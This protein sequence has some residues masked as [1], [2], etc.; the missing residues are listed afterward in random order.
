LISDCKVF[1][2]GIEN[3]CAAFNEWNSWNGYDNVPLRADSISGGGLVSGFL[4]HIAAGFGHDIFLLRSLVN[5]FR[6]KNQL[7]SSFQKNIYL[8]RE[9]RFVSLAERVIEN[10]FSPF[11]F[12]ADSR[13]AAQPKD[14]IWRLCKKKDIALVLACSP[15]LWVL[16]IFC[17]LLQKTK[18]ATFFQAFVTPGK[19]ISFFLLKKIITSLPAGCSI[20]TEEIFMREA[21]W[22]STFAKSGNI[23]SHLIQHGAVNGIRIPHRLQF[24]CY[25]CHPDSVNLLKSYYSGGGA[26]FRCN[27]KLITFLHRPERFEPIEKKE[28]YLYVAWAGQGL[29]GKRSLELMR[30]LLDEIENI[31]L[32]IYPHPRE[33]VSVY[34]ELEKSNPTRIDI[35]PNKRVSNIDVVASQYSTLVWEYVEVFPDVIGIVFPVKEFQKIDFFENKNIQ[36]CVTVGDFSRHLVNKLGNKVKRSG[37]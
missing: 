1:F 11:C 9:K 23:P 8:Y 6:L 21:F 17:G 2:K 26:E 18:V 22:I 35:W 25:H 33:D 16:F 13:R 3:E 34:S 36:R 19:V 10:D 29:H 4:K 7:G 24:E 14:E 30:S 20:Y 27:G 12:H 5:V 15:F 28:G 31:V 37:S 32:I